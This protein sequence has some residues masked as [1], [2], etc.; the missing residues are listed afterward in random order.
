MGVTCA[1]CSNILSTRE[2]YPSEPWNKV[3]DETPC[4]VV[5]PTIGALV[6]G[7]VLIISKRHVPCMGALTREELGEL[8]EVV[9]RIRGLTRSIYGSAVVFEHGPTCDGTTFGCGIDHAH[10][11]VIPLQV[12]LSPL[13]ERELGSSVVWNPIRHFKDLATIYQRKLSYLYLLE[14]DRTQG[15][16]ACLHDI[17]SQF[18]RRVIAG[19][20]GIPDLYD[21]R[22]HDFRQN[23]IKTLRR[24]EPAYCSAG[25]HFLGAT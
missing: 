11:H 10:F 15:S 8:E 1:Y 20:L 25:L 2:K 24:M 6:E 5:A 9:V 14:N 17:P 22:R 7:W 18:M 4:F 3:F 16:V 23:V 21:Y 12:P 13:V 19:H